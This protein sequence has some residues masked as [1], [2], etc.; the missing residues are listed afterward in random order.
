[1]ASKQAS[2]D[3]LC[4]L[5]KLR[6]WAG[7]V[8]SSRERTIVTDEF[9]ELEQDIELRKEGINK[10]HIASQSFHHALAKKKECEAVDEQGKLLP[11]DALGVVMITHGEELGEDSN[12]AI[13]R[14]SERD[15][16][17]AFCARSGAASCQTVSVAILNQRSGGVDSNAQQERKLESI[18]VSPEALV[19]NAIPSAMLEDW[20]RTATLISPMASEANL[21][22]GSALVKFGC[23]HCKVATLQE[24]F[25]LTFQDTFLTAMER[26]EAEIKDYQTQRKKL[27]SRRLSYD[28]AI[29]KAEKMKNNKK[30]KE[31]DKA[32]AEDELLKAKSRYE[33]TLEDVRAIM[34]A[35]QENESS[36]IRDL[37][38]FLEHE[39]N[40]VQ[41]YTEVLRD[42][43]LNWVDVYVLTAVFLTCRANTVRSEKAPP[44]P[45]ME[46]RRSSIRSHKSSASRSSRHPLSESEP[47]SDDEDEG[48]A[49]TP[50]PNK[51]SFSRRKSDAG[52]KAPSRPSSRTSRK[53]ADSEATTGGSTDKEKEKGHS[54]RLSVAGW[55]GSITGRGKSKDKDQFASLHEDEAVES[56]EDDARSEKSGKSEVSRSSRFSMRS[57]RSESV[58]KP[59][60]KSKSK[61]KRKSVSGAVEKKAVK[62]LYDFTPSSGDE[63]SFRT[64]DVITV[65]SEVLDGW[66]M[67]ELNGQTGLFPTTYTEPIASRTTP[68]VPPRPAPRR[69]NTENSRSSSSSLSSGA[70]RTPRGE[71]EEAYSDGYGTSDMEQEAL[72]TGPP[73]G[74]ARTP[75]YASFDQSSA[76]SSIDGEEAKLMPQPAESDTS[77]K[78]APGGAIAAS[79]KHSLLSPQILNNRF[80]SDSS[81]T[82]KRAPPPP[83]PARRA[84][85]NV[86]A[87]D[88]SPFD[89]PQASTF[90]LAGSGPDGC[91][92]FKQNPFKPPGMCSNCFEMHA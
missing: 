85:A 62:A 87:A 43:K 72:Y 55:M 11:V 59:E 24:A 10:L 14:N 67:G 2:S 20:T 36:Q 6:Q 44:A 66:W 40:F 80:K 21:S 18:G 31:K 29:S 81:P 56:E 13:G 47:D 22:I 3:I 68:P 75:V 70:Y 35:I 60:S 28:A 8:I 51:Q 73:L 12:Q 48:E 26:Y 1:M 19:R 64:G 71:E 92:E 69:A 42:A 86:V 34:V 61:P 65:I 50:G 53:R 82:G 58:S 90:D 39:M 91:R 63:L 57:K 15:A 45:R 9:R 38:T 17:T 74:S 27:E 89:S 79:L 41:Q 84:T 25:A 83:P 5:G 16:A 78:Q 33:E 37:T 30:E 52:S 76:R 46:S 4:S 77:K 54:K 23:A 49:E 32:D 7:E 88:A